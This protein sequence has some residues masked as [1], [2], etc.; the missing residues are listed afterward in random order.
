MAACDQATALTVGGKK[1]YYINK[2]CLYPSGIAMVV[3]VVCHFDLNF[4]LNSIQ[5]ATTLVGYE[6]MHRTMK[7]HSLILSSSFFPL[8]LTTVVVTTVNVV[9]VAFCL[10]PYKRSFTQL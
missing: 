8:Q 1:V 6:C 7:P 5:K 3:R 2:E 10:Y 9:Q 4:S